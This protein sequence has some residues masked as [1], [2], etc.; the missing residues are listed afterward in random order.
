M[1]RKY[2]VSYAAIA[3]VMEEIDA[4]SFED[5]LKL[6]RS[7]KGRLIECDYNETLD[8]TYFTVSCGGIEQVYNE[9]GGL[10]DE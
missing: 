8:G 2:Q 1:K 10:E 5:A 9:N 4:E 3:D 7:G 6:V